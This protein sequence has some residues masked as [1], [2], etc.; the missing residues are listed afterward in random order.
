MDPPQ[1]LR[2]SAA[3][4]ERFGEAPDFVVRSPGRVNLIG[5]HTD[6]NDGFVMPLAIEQSL[7]IAAGPASGRRVL[8][9][10]LDREGPPADFSLDQIK[11][12]EPG[13]T[14]YLIGV[15]WALAD[16][17][18]KLEGWRGVV[19][20]EIPIGAGL[21]SSAAFELGAARAFSE[22]S[23]FDWGPVRMAKL[24]RRVEN[25]WVGVNSGIMDQL[26]IALALPGAALK[27]DCRSLEAVPVRIPG[28]LRV[29]I[30][31]SA[32]RRGA[33]GLADSA[34]NERREECEAAARILGVA[35]L[36]EAGLGEL[37]AISGAMPD[38][39]FRRARHVITENARVE[40]AAAAMKSGDLDALGNLLR[41]SHDSMRKDFE[42]TRPEIDTLVDIANAHSE[43]I[44]AR[45]TGGGFGGCVVALVAA[46]G[47]PAFI[48]EVRSTYLEA[49]GLE[50]AFY[51]T[52]AAGGVRIIP[53]PES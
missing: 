19:S 27:I 4:R 47:V 38:R 16:A 51:E 12:R 36:R 14:A 50:G 3:Y 37:E 11:N 1:L 33:S 9:H 15:A 52:T 22:V 31:D 46:R 48:R 24:G 53:P 8:V 30:I 42:I 7:F 20:S 25:E 5:E 45:M 2:A 10:S 23:G 40:T 18:I 34:Y 49:V 44:G 26:I 39:V 13:W 32:T 28:D 21:S 17:G 6:Y 43:C 29:V 35:S 41:A